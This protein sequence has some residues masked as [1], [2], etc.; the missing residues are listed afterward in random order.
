MRTLE[1]KQDTRR[2]IQMGGLV[3]KAGLEN[4]ST[5]VLYGLLLEAAE[6]L[7]SEEAESVKSRWRLKG[8]I[9]LTMSEGN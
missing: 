2:K 5:A 6:Y 1:R 4:E 8:D 7:Q 9:G 3:K